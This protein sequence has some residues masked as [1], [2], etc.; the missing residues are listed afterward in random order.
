MSA[1]ANMPISRHTPLLACL[2]PISVWKENS[3]TRS[4]SQC[5]SWKECSSFSYH[6]TARPNNT[7]TNNKLGHSSCRI[8]NLEGGKEVAPPRTADRM[9]SS[10]FSIPAEGCLESS[11]CSRASYQCLSINFSNQKNAFVISPFRNPPV[12]HQHDETSQ[13]K[14]CF[15]TLDPCWPIYLPLDTFHRRRQLQ[16]NILCFI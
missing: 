10:S 8:R 3:R 9:C 16:P 1:G 2:S 6:D 13:Y 11:F 14:F 15:P 7:N 12:H 4:L 5:I